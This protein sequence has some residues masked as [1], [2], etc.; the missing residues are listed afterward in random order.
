MG[1]YSH[2][3]GDSKSSTCSVFIQPLLIDSAQ[4]LGSAIPQI[5]A[6]RNPNVTFQNQTGTFEILNPEKR[7]RVPNGIR[8][9]LFG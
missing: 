2:P 1:G 4:G 3:T 5:G 9:A 7:F 8:F 6:P